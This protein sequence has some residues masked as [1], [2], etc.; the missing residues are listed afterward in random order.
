M[1]L[2]LRSNPAG[3]SYL[4]YVKTLQRCQIVLTINNNALHDLDGGEIQKLY[5]SKSDESQ[6]VRRQIGHPLFIAIYG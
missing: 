5:K 4:L 1:I 6:R 2:S 3:A